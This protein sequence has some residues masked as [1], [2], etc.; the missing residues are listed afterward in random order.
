MH[1]YRRYLLKGLVGVGGLFLVSKY[2]KSRIADAEDSQDFSSESPRKKER[3]IGKTARRKFENLQWKRLSSNDADAIK[4]EYKVVV[5]GS[6]YGASVAAARLSEKVGGELCLL[7]RGREF[8]PGE[9]PAGATAAL[10][11]VRLD[12]VR[13]LGSYNS[14]RLGIFNLTSTGGID[15]VT[16]NGLGGGSNINADPS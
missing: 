12:G 16:G 7:E 9:Y 8:V 1:N 6:G 10:K 4:S 5:I 14:N 2:F 13:L 3:T 15:V 11:N